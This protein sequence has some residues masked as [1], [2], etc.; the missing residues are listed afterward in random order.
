[1]DIVEA[2]RRRDLT[3]NA[4]AVD[5]LRQELL[6]PFGG[7]EDMRKKVL[8]SP[9]PRF[10]QED[11][12]RFFRVMQ[13]IGRFE[14]YPDSELQAICSSMPINTV[15]RERIEEEFKKLFLG[16]LRPSLGI[17]WLADI[18][19]LVEILPELAVLQQIEQEP[20]WHP[21]GSVF[22]HT[23]Q[24]IDAAVHEF[25]EYDN[26]HK[27]VGIYAGLCHDLGKAVTTKKINGR[28]RSFNHAQAGVP[29]SKKLL[30]RITRNQLLVSMVSL[31][32]EYHM[33]PVEWIKNNAKPTAYKKLAAKLAP[34]VNLL[35]LALLAQADKRGRNPQ[36]HSPLPDP[37]AQVQEFI[38][39]AREFGVLHAPEPPLVQGKDLLKYIQA[40]PALGAAVSAAYT[41]QLERDIHDKE[42]LIAHVLNSLQ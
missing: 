39:K 16:S 3:M 17:R 20:T 13:S 18:K 21:E 11:P 33:V 2:L 1:M 41:I 29:L 5:I 42:E 10:F 4:M 26:F 14:M 30:A 35:M 9:D 23:M 25:S 38:N 6:D 40:G 28:I 8:R 19:R 34:Q 22:E 37:I 12:L 27:L 32:V 24:T 36:A 15:S 7:E 31:L